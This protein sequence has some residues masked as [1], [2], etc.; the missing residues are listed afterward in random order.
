MG[1]RETGITTIG[2]CPL[3]VYRLSTSLHVT[4]PSNPSPSVF[5]YCKDWRLEWPGNE[6][7]FP[8]IFHYTMLN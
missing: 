6:A 5:A 8:P 2:H 4:K 3:C 1:R 7:G